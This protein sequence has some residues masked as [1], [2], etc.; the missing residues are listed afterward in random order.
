[1]IVNGT[2]LDTP[3]NSAAN[4]MLTANITIP[5]AL[6][7]TPIGSESNAYCG[8]FDGNNHTISGLNITNVGSY[9]GMFG[10]IVNGT[11]KNLT[12][13]GHMTIAGNA[14]RVGG[15][16]G[17]MDGG[18]LSGIISKME[19]SAG[20]GGSHYG[21]IVGSIGYNGQN[22]TT[23]E[24][25]I[26]SGNFEIQNN[27]CLGGIAGYA[28]KCTIRNCANLGILTVTGTSDNLV[29]GIFA[30]CNDSEVKVENC[31]NSGLIKLAMSNSMNSGALFGGV[32]GG[33][34]IAD[35]FW[36][37]GSCN[38]S[39]GYGYQV[40][41][42]ISCEKKTFADFGSGA[43]AVLLQG[44]QTELAWG[45][46]IGTD[47]YPVLTTDEAKR[48][49]A[50]KMY[51]GTAE[52]SDVYAGASGFIMPEGSNAV[53][54]IEPSVAVE[55]TGTNVIV[56]DGDAYTCANLVLTDGADFYTPVTFTAGKATYS[57]KLPET[58]TW[59][60]IVLP[61]AAE[62]IEGG[63]LYEATEIV[64]DGSDES[65]LAKP[66]PRLCSKARRPERP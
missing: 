13:A 6:E 58:S 11:V 50:A 26:F 8:T 44:D 5:E 30:Y 19:L 32:K 64:A 62:T 65:I 57:R 25:C 63:S 55:A 40:N 51:N 59:G 45:Q 10:K 37:E 27:D 47:D 12:I 14:I 34:E 38:N 15:L 42:Q 66:I 60:T 23:L 53:A 52:P 2:L 20:N 1:M 61:F 31:Y 7:W 48:V 4:A 9:S 17:F 49:Y 29:G 3:Q 46:T 18:T 36:L 39:K 33:A 28:K 16:V 54:V 22:L 43:V 56:K 24:R 35:C 41:S 21:G